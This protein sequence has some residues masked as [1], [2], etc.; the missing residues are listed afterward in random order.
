M[1]GLMA[2]WLA[3]LPEPVLDHLPALALAAALAWGA[4]LRLYLVVFA[5]GLPGRFGW[6]PLPENLEVLAH[7]VVFLVALLVFLVAAV[8][9]LFAIARGLR[10]LFGSERAP[11]AA[12]DR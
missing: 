3:L 10:R 4:G 9:L 1:N 6:W 2:Q 8:L 7:P 5:F 12:V 11:P